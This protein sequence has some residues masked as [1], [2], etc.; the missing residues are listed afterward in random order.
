MDL[1]DIL[2][3][4]IE[5]EGSCDWANK[6][7]E[8]CDKCPLGELRRKPN[9]DFYSCIEA[10]SIDGLNEREANKR[11][12]HTAEEVLQDIE[13]EDILLGDENAEDCTRHTMQI[14]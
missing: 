8:V 9:G 10:L 12:K 6:C 2:R 1:K 14:I 5:E 13:I 4:I 7:P 11:Y 3:K